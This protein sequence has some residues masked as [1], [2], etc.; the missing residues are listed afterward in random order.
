MVPLSKMSD[1]CN[2]HLLDLGVEDLSRAL[3][4]ALH[5]HSTAETEEKEGKR[6]YSLS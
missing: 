2:S 6:S 4:K 5:V 3:F 1:R